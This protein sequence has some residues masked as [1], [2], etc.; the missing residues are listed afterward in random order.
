MSAIARVVQAGPLPHPEALE[1]F[2]S[3]ALL[4]PVWYPPRRPAV[5]E[6]ARRLELRMLARMWADGCFSPG[7]ETEAILAGARRIVLEEP[8][9]IDYDRLSDIYDRLLQD[10]AGTR[11]ARAALKKS[12]RPLAEELSRPD[13]LAYSL[14]AHAEQYRT[15]VASCTETLVFGQV[16]ANVVLLNLPYRHLDWANVPP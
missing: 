15:S 14:P 8:Y 1:N 5:A 2:R 3:R 13:P 4:A 7:G 9:E 12:V 11:Q 16:D 6:L 10:Y